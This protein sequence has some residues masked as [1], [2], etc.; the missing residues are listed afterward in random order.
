[1][2]ILDLTEVSFPDGV[3][4]AGTFGSVELISGTAVYDNNY[5]KTDLYAKKTFKN[6]LD[7]EKEKSINLY[8]RTASIKNK[9]D[10][11]AKMVFCN[12]SKLQLFIELIMGN[13]LNDYV[14]EFSKSYDKISI[15]LYHNLLSKTISAINHLHSINII[16]YDIKGNNLMVKPNGEIVIIDFSL[17][18]RKGDSVGAF[19]IPANYQPPEVT[20]IH[21]AKD[22]IDV[23]QMGVCFLNLLRNKQSGLLD[24]NFNV[25]FS[26][27]DAELE[28]GIMLHTQNDRL[29][30]NVIKPFLIKCISKSSNDR[31]NIKQTFLP[32]FD[33]SQQIKQHPLNFLAPLKNKLTSK[34]NELADTLKCLGKKYE[35]LKVNVNGKSKECDQLKEENAALKL[36]LQN[37]ATKRFGMENLLEAEKIKNFLKDE[38]ILELTTKIESLDDDY[39]VCMQELHNL[40]LDFDTMKS[41]C[42]AQTQDKEKEDVQENQQMSNE[43]DNMEVDENELSEE[44]SVY[45]LD[46]C[47]IQYSSNPAE[48]VIEAGSSQHMDIDTQNPSK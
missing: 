14:A 43:C 29:L 16:H 22:T 15:N 19:Q 35:S 21:V 3:I 25:N 46:V 4:G 9:I 37:E 40:K 28:K 31:P 5:K 18:A 27:I 26:Q 45:P 6:V 34:I 48:A 47:Q 38:R 41:K 36:K 20:K 7:Y 23:F 10:C 42:D 17:S 1:M 13:T 44:T 39:D 32:L 2:K 33:A 12:D 8:I 11:I 30:F 24:S